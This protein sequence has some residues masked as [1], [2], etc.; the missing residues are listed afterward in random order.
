MGLVGFRLT[1]GGPVAPAWGQS[2][3]TTAGTAANA[4]T[5]SG[6]PSPEVN[7][8]APTRL[9]QPTPAAK[10]GREAEPQTEREAVEP[11]APYVPGEFER[12][13]QRSL[14]A[15]RIQR[16]G[17]EL[18]TEN[19]DNRAQ[20]VSPLAPPDY[21]VGPGDEVLLTVWGSVDAD[22]RLIVDRG[23]RIAVP[24]VGS[25]QVAGLRYADLQD[26][27]GR[28]IALTYKNFQL[29]VSLGQLRGLRVY[30]TGA[31]V[32]PGVHSVQSL[33]TVLA[34]LLRAGG[35]TAAG[36]F[37]NIE[38]RR[39]SQLVAN[40]DLYDFLLRG[41]RSADR[42]LQA[43]DVVHVGP[44]GAQ[45]ALLG[46][47]NRPAVFELKAGETVADVLQMA[48]GFNS[49]ADRSRLAVERLQE[50]NSGRVALISL[51][52]ALGEKPGSGD[53]LRAFSAVDSALP[54]QPQRKRVRVEGEVARPGEYVL[55]P[56][57]SVADAVR[58][59]GGLTGNAFVFGTEF[60]RESVRETQQLNYDRALRDLETDFARSTATQR[61][62]SA[63]EATAQNSR[64]TANTRLIERLRAI[65]PSG[66]IVLQIPP[67][68]RELPDLAL[69]DGDRISI[70]PR[71]S[72]VG[73]F[74]SVFNGGNYLFSG[75]RKLADYLRLAGGPTRG[76]DED[77][78]FVI[79]ANG[80]V[81]S[82]LQTSTWLGFGGNSFGGLAA[83]PGDT[84][85]VP[86][87]LDK[88]TFIQN[89]KDWTQIMYQFALGAAAVKTFKN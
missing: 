5:T 89:A 19:F 24:R 16:F 77:S 30:V 36:S 25:V 45:V 60:S 52:E 47:V 87:K 22:L 72:S 15:A 67:D 8:L 35:P 7:P 46:S 29:S 3:A 88:T 6:D 34:A 79:R 4:P 74:G 9:R 82:G 76:A 2:S 54:S 20:E 48:G 58:A 37:R 12:F 38:L 14:G 55:P 62:S 33:S 69:E 42:L 17:A 50:R 28:R 31:V 39:G 80:S 41:D 68:G 27:I 11:R 64:G 78:T 26:A 84:V 57:S 49:V 40:F 85:Y 71:P 18:V 32:N 75:D 1:L 51:P 86:E 13:V 73:V 44:V 63:D 65:K 66:R 59:A 70:P 21:L 10:P 56:E 53:V 61:V 43:G 83:L 81:V 23:G